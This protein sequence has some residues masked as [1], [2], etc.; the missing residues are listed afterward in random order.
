M[1]G[2]N[3]Q[4]ISCVCSPRKNESVAVTKKALISKGEQFKFKC[5][6]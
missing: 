2:E 6:K 5:G 1:H 3:R 4:A